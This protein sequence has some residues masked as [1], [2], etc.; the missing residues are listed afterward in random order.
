MCV[1]YLYNT[2]W[3]RRMWFKAWHHE[4]HRNVT[5][6]HH[7]VTRWRHKLES[8]GW[9]HEAKWWRDGGVAASLRNIE[10]FAASACGSQSALRL[11]RWVPVE[12]SGVFW[13]ARS[14]CWPLTSGSRRFKEWKEKYI[15]FLN[16]KRPAV[17]LSIACFLRVR[18]APPCREDAA[19]W[20]S[21]PCSVLQTKLF[22]QFL[23]ISIGQM[24]TNHSGWIYTTVE[25]PPSGSE[26]VVV[27]VN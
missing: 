18:P 16:P 13:G 27:V 17:R 11:A 2:E 23:Y 14:R 5:L 25:L 8:W 9:R 22:I 3:I 19:Y 24:G 26:T 12:G 1:K 4:Q 6:W 21:D 20:D 10:V 15:R 7:E